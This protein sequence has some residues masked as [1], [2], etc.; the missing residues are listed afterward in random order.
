M[1]LL[2]SETELRHLI[3]YCWWK[4]GVPLGSL[5]LAAETETKNDNKGVVDVDD[6]V[7]V[8]VDIIIDN[9]KELENIYSEWKDGYVRRRIQGLS[10]AFER[11]KSDGM[12]ITNVTDE[13]MRCETKRNKRNNYAK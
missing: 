11:W 7:D 1:T 9:R 3:A 5:L 8:D 4:K 10:L 2:S 12:L 13:E 6:D